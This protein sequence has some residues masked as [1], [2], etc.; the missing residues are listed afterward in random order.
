MAALSPSRRECLVVT[1]CVPPFWH[2]VMSDPTPPYARRGMAVRVPPRGHRVLTYPRP[3]R[4]GRRVSTVCV[5]PIW[6]RVMADP[7]R[8]CVRRAPCRDRPRA[9]PIWHRVH[10]RTPR[11]HH[12]AARVMHRL[13]AMPR[14][15]PC[16]YPRPAPAEA[17]GQH[18]LRAATSGTGCRSLA[19]VVRRRSPSTCRTEDTGYQRTHGPRTAGAPGQ[20][21]LRAM[22]NATVARPA[23]QTPAAPGELAPHPCQSPHPHP[24][25][26]PPRH[27][28]RTR[29]V[30][31][32][33]QVR[34]SP[35]KRQS[36][37]LH[38]VERGRG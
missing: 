25:A 20:H 19:R 6:H 1:V 33:Y 32:R 2:R 36:T 7:R 29:P 31:P 4:P 10:E 17:P 23:G 13:R 27:Y 12:G 38:M 8:H 9:A 14:T 30:P 5:P 3:L 34:T 11:R 35:R 16:P 24:P 37:P 15:P 22:A 28:Q 18:C 26:L 21:R